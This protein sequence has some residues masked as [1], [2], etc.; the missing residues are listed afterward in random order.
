[1]TDYTLT[2]ALKLKDTRFKKYG[3]MHMKARNKVA[4]V[5]FLENP[6]LSHALFKLKK[7]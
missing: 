6:F 2:L 1:M 5:G 4:L 3:V 7:T